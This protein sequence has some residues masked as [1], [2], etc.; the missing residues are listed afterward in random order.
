MSSF[1]V[2][3]P[4]VKVATDRFRKTGSGICVS[5]NQHQTSYSYSRDG[6]IFDFSGTLLGNTGSGQIDWIRGSEKISYTGNWRDGVVEVFTMISRH[7][8]YHHGEV[9]FQGRVYPV[10]PGDE[11]ETTHLRVRVSGVILSL[12]VVMG[13]DFLLSR[14]S[15]FQFEL[16]E[17]RFEVVDGVSVSSLRRVIVSADPMGVVEFSC[18]V[19]VDTV[20]NS[21]RN[22]STGEVEEMVTKILVPNGA[23]KFS[24]M[25]IFRENS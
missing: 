18:V 23:S 8:S 22:H 7:V 2:I 24:R 4:E 13:A 5:C 19:T 11:G 1:S 12:P 25:I 10:E 14:E 20:T 9:T 15:D 3:I 17:Q 6:D 21:W 16:G